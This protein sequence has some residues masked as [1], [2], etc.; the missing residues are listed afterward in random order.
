MS[1]LEIWA[2]PFWTFGAS[3]IS[4]FPLPPCAN[5]LR[6]DKPKAMALPLGVAPRV[7]PASQLTRADGIARKGCRP[8]NIREA[9]LSRA[10]L[11]KGNLSKAT[12]VG[13]SSTWLSQRRTSAGRSSTSEPRRGEP[14]RGEPYEGEP[15]RG[16]AKLVEAKLSGRTS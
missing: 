5:A 10:D 4:Q 12:S 8:V 9:D 13:P 6:P 3:L 11:R 14:F 7:S 1:I 15:Q 16:D 2:C